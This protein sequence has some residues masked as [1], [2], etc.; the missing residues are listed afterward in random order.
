MTRIF[1]LT[2]AACALMTTTAM[3]DGHCA[4]GKTLDEGKFT[5]ATGNPAYYPWVMDNAPE[6]GKGFEAAVAYSVAAEMGFAA[7]DVVWVRS[8]F[9]EAIQPGAK[10]FDVN[11]QQYSITPER[12]EIVD[13][14]APYYSAP[15]AVLVSPG[16]IDTAP[17]MA[18]LKA[19]KW[20][21]VGSTTAVSKLAEVVKP[22]GDLLLYGDN[23]DVNAAM[24]ANQIDAALFDLPTALFLSAVMIE[25]SKVIG[26]FP[27]DAGDSLDQFG[28]LLEDGNPLK[29]CVDE[30][31]AAMTENGTLAALEAEWMQDTTGVPLIK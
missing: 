19:L 5:I 17:T 7:D 14:S 20:G 11:M 25:G 27:A 26:Q 12:D 13:F 28:M 2:V 3:A 24:T 1:A 8:S 21:A 15:M 29:A 10:N 22:D 18:A 30:A 23:A 31:L 16:A 9:D 4:A 6:S